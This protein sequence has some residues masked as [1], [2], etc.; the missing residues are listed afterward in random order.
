M[1]EKPMKVRVHL[2]ATLQMEP[3]YGEAYRYNTF[4]VAV[5]IEDETQEGETALVANGRLRKEAELIFE[6]NTKGQAVAA[7]R[8]IDEARSEQQKRAAAISGD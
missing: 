1:E 4:H 2:G 6:K 3:F 5:D 8:V 7:K